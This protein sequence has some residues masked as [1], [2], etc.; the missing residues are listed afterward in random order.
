[1]TKEMVKMI[2]ES[3]EIVKLCCP[4]LAGHLP[5]VQSAALADLTAIW[6]SGYYKADEALREELFANFLKCVRD[7]IPVNI[8]IRKKQEENR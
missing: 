8:E 2:E 4:H 5:E 6:L 3:Q 1:M 7:L